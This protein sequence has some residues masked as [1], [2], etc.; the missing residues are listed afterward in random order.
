MPGPSA[1]GSSSAIYEAEEIA[2]LTL[3]RK[4]TV[5]FE[6]VPFAVLYAIALYYCVTTFGQPYEV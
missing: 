4:R 3:R 1:S 6:H 2:S 5:S